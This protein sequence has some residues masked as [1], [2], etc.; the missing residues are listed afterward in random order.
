MSPD[1]SA[2]EN[3]SNRAKFSVALASNALQNQALK[4]TKVKRATTGKLKHITMGSKIK[5]FTFCIR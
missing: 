2:G 5:R 3:V 1:I 4:G